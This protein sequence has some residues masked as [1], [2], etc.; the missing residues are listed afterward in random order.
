MVLSHKPGAL[1]E[2]AVVRDVEA[3]ATTN[4]RIGPYLR[5]GHPGGAGAPR[6]GVATRRRRAHQG[7]RRSQA[8]AGQA[9]CVAVRRAGR[10]DRTARR[11]GRGAV[12]PRGLGLDPDVLA[13]ERTVREHISVFNRRC[14]TGSA[15]LTR[16]RLRCW[17]SGSSPTCSPTPWSRTPCCRGCSPTGDPVRGTAAARPGRFAGSCRAPRS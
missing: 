3:E 6:P 8:D 1:P 15:T 5:H 9:Q 10:G 11:A 16:C 2:D 17:T 13:G 7:V 12:R 4:N 14:S